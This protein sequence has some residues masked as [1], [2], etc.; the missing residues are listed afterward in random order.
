MLRI[1]LESGWCLQDGVEAPSCNAVNE[2]ADEEALVE[3]RGVRLQ[4]CSGEQEQREYIV[5]DSK[6]ESREE[7]RDQ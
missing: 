5:M 6:A 4:A 2:E 7:K 3:K 1:A